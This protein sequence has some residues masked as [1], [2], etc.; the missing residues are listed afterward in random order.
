MGAIESR[1]QPCH[2]LTVTVGFAEGFPVEV[3]LRLR[4]KG[5]LSQYEL[6]HD[7]DTFRSEI[8]GWAR[9][10]ALHYQLVFRIYSD[11]TLYRFL[12]RDPR[13]LA[14]LEKLLHELSQALNS[15][16]PEYVPALEKHDGYTE[17]EIY[18][19]FMDIACRVVPLLTVE[20]DL[21]HAVPSGWMSFFYRQRDLSSIINN[22][23]L[24][25]LCEW[26]VSSCQW[27]LSFESGL[28]EGMRLAKAY[29][30]QVIVQLL[31]VLQS[32]YIGSIPGI[33]FK[34]SQGQSLRDSEIEMKSMG[35]SVR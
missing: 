15:A 1:A 3:M 31:C 30:E 11:Q 12:S 22:T 25:L 19:I 18:A 21:G 13:G 34:F 24:P 29:G 10:C 7:V 28:S 2:A 20:R 16:S 27:R 26:S 4:H 33:Q 5:G 35:L 23:L 9:E 17:A 14:V 6:S 32:I 8:D